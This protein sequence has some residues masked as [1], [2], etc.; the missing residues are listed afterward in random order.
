MRRGC[1]QV[2]LVWSIV[3]DIVAGFK[4]KPRH[5][6]FERKSAHR[7]LQ[8]DRDAMSLLPD[9]KLGSTDRSRRISSI[10]DIESISI[11]YNYTDCW[12][13]GLDIPSDSDIRTSSLAV[14]TERVFAN[15]AGGFKVAHKRKAKGKSG[16]RTSRIHSHLHSRSHLQ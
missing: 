11:L 10:H 6:P 9:Y 14:L 4:T 2:C 7:Q 12:M 8:L 13:L 15:R 5:F 1:L 16:R 3:G